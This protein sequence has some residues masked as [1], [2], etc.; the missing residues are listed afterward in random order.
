[1]RHPQP[2]GDLVFRHL[3][4]SALH[5]GNRGLRASDDDVEVR[6]LE[7]LKGRVQHPLL[8]DAPDAHRGHGGAEGDAAHV[9]RQRNPGQRHHVGVVLLVGGDDVD[10]ELRFVLKAV[11]EE[12]P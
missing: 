4:R 11:G 3:Q 6:V 7:L 8:L 2:F 5:H 12:R 1:M 10:K 9:Q